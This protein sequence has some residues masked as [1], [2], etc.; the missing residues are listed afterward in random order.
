M[1]ILGST[2]AT[3]VLKIEANRYRTVLCSLSPS[4]PRL[5]RPSSAAFAA[6]R[7]DGTVVTWGDPER[8]GNSSAVFWQMFG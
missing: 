7:H 6:L 3:V 2:F 1:K 8:G 5:I 4:F